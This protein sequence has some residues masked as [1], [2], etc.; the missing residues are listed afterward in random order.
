MTSIRR[1][2]SIR[3]LWLVA[4]LSVGLAVTNV[5]GAQPGTPSTSHTKGPSVGDL[6]ILRDPQA[7][8]RPA[9]APPVDTL[10]PST[11][12]I[13][14]SVEGLYPGASQPLNLTLA[15]SNPSPIRVTS[16]SI[17]VHNASQACL[18]SNLEFSG[19]TET[20]VPPR[21]TAITT[22]LAHLKSSSAGNCQGMTWSL[23][24]QGT[25]E[26]A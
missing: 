10:S 2:L 25:A 16:V 12:Q 22:V 24:Y 5:G 7:P 9:T 15:N 23:S 3:R 8:P 18:G 17:T 21:S 6:Q 26:Q 20:V 1:L 11:F 19:F 14:G 4:P 13:S